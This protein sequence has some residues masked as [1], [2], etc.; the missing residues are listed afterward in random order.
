LAVGVIQLIDVNVYYM[1]TLMMMERYYILVTTNNSLAYCHS[2]TH[3]IYTVVE[4]NM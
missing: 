2:Y 1:P 4:L 3:I